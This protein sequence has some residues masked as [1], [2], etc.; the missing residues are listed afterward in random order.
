MLFFS[1]GLMAKPMLVTLPFVLLLFDYWPLQRFQPYMLPSLKDPNSHQRPSFLQLI[2]EKIPLLLLSILSSAVT[3]YAQHAGGAVG[4]F[5]V[6]PVHIRIANAM[7][8]YASY[9]GKMLWPFHLAVFYPHPLS[10]MPWWLLAG[11][12]LLLI[13]ISSLAILGA[14]KYPWFIVGW[15]WYLGTLVPVIGIVQVG[16]QAMADRYT[17]MPL[18]GLFVI[19]AWGVPEL[20]GRWRYKGIG[21]AI[22]AGAIIVILMT[23]TAAQI[24]YWKDDVSISQHAID[25]TSHNYLA[26]NNL[27]LALE[28]QGRTAEATEHFIEALKINPE[29]LDAQVNLGINLAGQGRIGEAI[30]HYTKALQI[31]PG[32]L[33]A[34]FNLGSALLSQGMVDSAIEH[35]KKATQ[36]D[37][38][39]GEAHNGLGV[40]LARKGDREGAIREFQEALRIDPG[41]VGAQGNLEKLLASRGLVDE[42][43]A[44]IKK[45][46]EGDPGNTGLYVKLGDVYRRRG[47]IDKAMESY[48]KA[49]SMEPG[50]MGALSNLAVVYAGKG[51]FDKALNALRKVIEVQP[52]SV[53]AYYN[54]ACIYARQ[55]KVDESVK[56]LK[57]AVDK[58]FA[59]WGLLKKDRDLESIRGTA[60]YEDLMKR[61]GSG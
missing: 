30:D 24:S 56:W 14:R 3:L 10:V 17:Y 5:E 32:S 11:A 48:E 38:R 8:S 57:E 52:G 60:Y 43:S 47:D 33:E 50:N 18:I 23:L 12:S 6:F 46:I 22:S 29:Y 9:M 28:S 16:L 34:H 4:S 31:K 58:G 1:L 25:V 61:H 54:I 7:V 55:G 19:I 51:E 37:P 20:V 26:H 41:N 42:A 53:G 13:I 45:A 2:W 35:F 59:D 40:A 39:S 36:I 15:L 44:G 27:G 21:L 49:L